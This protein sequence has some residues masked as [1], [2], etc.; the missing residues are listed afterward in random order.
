MSD[1]TEIDKKPVVKSKAVGYV[2]PVGANFYGASFTGFQK[3]GEVTDLIA[4]FKD[5][6]YQA[7]VKDPNAT[8]KQ[9]VKEF[10]EQVC[11]PM[12]RKFHPYLNALRAWRKKWDLDLLQQMTGKEIV[13]AEDL[14]K[15]NIHQVI[16]TR[17]DEKAL[18]VGMPTDNELEGGLRTLGGE[19]MNDALQMLRD[20]QELEEI[21]TS[22]ELIKRRS[23]I[24]GVF[25]H[26]TKLVHGKAALM[27]KAS[28]ERR[29]NAGFMMT[30]LAKASAGKISDEEM[31]VL[32]ASY[33]PTQNV[34][35]TA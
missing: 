28:E 27:L 12:N 16:K 1:T 34:G 15:R 14:E 8:L 13:L 10:N 6:Y 26:V 4:A 11:W 21:Y 25:G 24:V 20:D 5:S 18:V 3:V 30:L 31:E 7:K 23:Y 2:D 19:L 35:S 29:N 9:V 22:D 33:K 17:N 32:E